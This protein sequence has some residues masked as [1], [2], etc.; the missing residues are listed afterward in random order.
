MKEKILPFRE[1]EWWLMTV[2][3]FLVVFTNTLGA[4][5]ALNRLGNS[6]DPNLTARYFAYIFIP[7][8]LYA[9]FYFLHVRILPAYKKEGRKAKTVWQA[10][11]TFFGSWFVVGFFYINAG[12]G[13]DP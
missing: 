9:A 6:S 11:L 7:L 2:I 8:A 13:S 5:I 10:L 12:F 4:K 1:I 3:I